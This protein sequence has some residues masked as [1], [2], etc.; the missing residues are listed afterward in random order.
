MRKN[1]LC[2]VSDKQVN[3][4][5]ARTHA[6]INVFIL[7]LFLFTQSIFLLLFLLID[8][9]VRIANLPQYSLIGRLARAIS[10]R[11]PVKG[12]FENAGPKLFAARI[13]WLF[14][15]L[16]IVFQLSGNITLSLSTAGILLFFSFL[17][18]AFS[19]C[20]ACII[21][22]YFYKV[23]FNNGIVDK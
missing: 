17:E 8:F 7:I 15:G 23:V 19:F 1:A 3:T 10:D 12:K 4:I 2:P 14:T 18:A 9:S 13:G 5:T 22:P 16:I 6:F 20:V 21:Y 11:L